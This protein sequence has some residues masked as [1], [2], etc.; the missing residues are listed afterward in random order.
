MQASDGLQLGMGV[1]TIVFSVNRTVQKLIPSDFH[2]WLEIDGDILASVRWVWLGHSAVNYIGGISD[3]SV[4]LLVQLLKSVNWHVER[5]LAVESVEGYEEEALKAAQAKRRQRLTGSPTEKI[6]P[7]TIPEPPA[8]GVEAKRVVHRVKIAR[9]GYRAA[10][11]ESTR[12]QNALAAANPARPSFHSYR[13]DSK[14]PQQGLTRSKGKIRSSWEW[15]AFEERQDAME[16]LVAE[17]PG[18]FTHICVH[19]IVSDNVEAWRRSWVET[20]PIRELTAEICK[21]EAEGRDA[22]ALSKKLQR[23]IRADVAAMRDKSAAKP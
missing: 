17:P 15:I 11:E 10:V 5:Q 3:P 12:R 18:T 9:A 8:M 2:W 13:S 1:E 16:A 19:G 23:V 4:I 7:I 21:Y 6:Q 20:R 22:T 14:I